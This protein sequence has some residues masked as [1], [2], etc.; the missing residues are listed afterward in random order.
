MEITDNEKDILRNILNEI[1]VLEDKE[2]NLTT[3][4]IKLEG[5]LDEFRPEFRKTFENVGT[6]RMKANKTIIS[7]VSKFSHRKPTLEEVY[8]AIHNILGSGF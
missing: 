6:N 3:E 8:N 1:V 7:R 4:K 5:T 2:K